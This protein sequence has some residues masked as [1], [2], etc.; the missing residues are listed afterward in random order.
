MLARIDFPEESINRPSAGQRIS[1]FVA[2][3]R[4]L[5]TI[6]GVQHASRKF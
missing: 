5:L 3:R 6:P 2:Q 1:A 4:L